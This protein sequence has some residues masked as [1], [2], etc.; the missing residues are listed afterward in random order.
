MQVFKKFGLAYKILYAEYS[1]TKLKDGGIVIDYQA[2][3]G[4]YA[5]LLLASQGIV[6][7]SE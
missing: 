3:I 4:I 6:I 7:Q 1:A 2:F 5:V